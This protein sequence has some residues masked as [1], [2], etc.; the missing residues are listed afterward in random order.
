MFRAFLRPVA[1]L[2]ALSGLA[3]YAAIMLR[4][5]Q[6]LEALAQK[7]TQIQSMVEYNVKLKHDNDLKQARIERLNSD[8]TAQEVELERHGY[9]HEGDTR[10][11]PAD[12]SVK[13]PVA[14][15]IHTP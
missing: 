10:F 15:A 13:V 12:P 14:G 2:A 5:P 6:G 8:R 9:M 7:H 11:T 1:A 3:A 4:G